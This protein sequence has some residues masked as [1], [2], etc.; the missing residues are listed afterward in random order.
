MAVKVMNVDRV[1]SYYLRKLH[2]EISILRGLDHP[3]IV[4]SVYIHILLLYSC[5]CCY[6]LHRIC[7][8]Y[9]LFLPLIILNLF[10]CFSQVG[11]QDVFYGRRSVYLVTHLCR[12]GE[13]FELLNTGNYCLYTCILYSICVV[14]CIRKQV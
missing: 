4:R 6:T 2:T 3:N 11:L 13:L 5:Y 10:I 8:L 14:I 1:T 7:I 12:G 9:V